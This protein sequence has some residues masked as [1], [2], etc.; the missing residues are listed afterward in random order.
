MCTCVP[1]NKTYYRSH[2]YQVKQQPIVV[3]SNNTNTVYYHPSV[4]V[5]PVNTRYVY[6]PYYYNH[7]KRPH[8]KRK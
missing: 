4:V 5:L 8:I 1:A 2:G 7:S 6:N 3:A